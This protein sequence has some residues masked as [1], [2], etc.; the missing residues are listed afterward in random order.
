MFVEDVVAFEA[1]GDF[2]FRAEDPGAPGVFAE[3]GVGFFQNAQGA[4]CDI[5]PDCR[6]GLRRLTNSRM[7]VHL[8]ELLPRPGHWYPDPPRLFRVPFGPVFHF[9]LFQKEP[10]LIEVDRCVSFVFKGSTE[11]KPRL[12]IPLTGVCTDEIHGKSC[13]LQPFQ[14]EFRI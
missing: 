14:I 1:R 2:K 7:M 5:P 8:R 4:E 13:L 12:V 10:D 11:L 6:W 3:N 9:F